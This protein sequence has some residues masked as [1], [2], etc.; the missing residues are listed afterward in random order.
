MKISNPHDLKNYL[1]AR[2]LKPKDY[3]GQNFLVDEQALQAIV[4]AADLK[5][6]DT[7]VEVGPGLGVLTGELVQKAKQVWA[8]EKD[9][10]LVDLLKTEFHGQKNLKLV[11]EDILRFHIARNI[12]SQYKVVANI[13]Y[14]LTSKLMQIFLEQEHP[15]KLMVLMIQKEVGERVV[16]KAGELSILG[17][18][19]QIY[20]D[21]E[22]VASVPRDSFWPVPEVDSVVIKIVPK[23]KYPEI[24]DKKLFFRIIKIAFAGKRKQ[25]LNSLSHGLHLNKAVVDE[26]LVKSGI[27]PHTRPQDLSISS[28]IELYKQVKPMFL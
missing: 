18:S 15:P 4:A 16:A 10:K 19:I 5:P 11:N 27:D 26:I 24:V 7:V 6:T 8:I 2:S 3:L 20:A 13:P 9:R 12:T 1:R 22:I 25:I 28:W 17:I 23:N 21:V 14:Y